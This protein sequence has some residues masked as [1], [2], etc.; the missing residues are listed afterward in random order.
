MKLTIEY[1]GHTYNYTEYTRLYLDLNH[2][3]VWDNNEP[4]NYS[5]GGKFEFNNLT[6]GI[7]LLRQ[8]TREECYQIIPGILYY[9]NVNYGD[10]FVDN[11]VKYYHHGHNNISGIHGGFINNNTKISNATFDFVLQN[12][13]DTY[14]SFYPNYTML[15]HLSM[16]RLLMVKEMILVLAH[17]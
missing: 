17:I 12:N 3:G 4:Y 8:E 5:L 9:T 13:F 11:I 2:N 16:N 1:Y 10:G 6:Q 14:V 7:Y 15:L